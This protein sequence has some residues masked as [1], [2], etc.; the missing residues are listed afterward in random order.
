MISRQTLFAK[1]ELAQRNL[2]LRLN[3]HLVPFNLFGTFFWQARECTTPVWLGPCQ[4][5]PY[6]YCILLCS[7]K[8]FSSQWPQTSHKYC[9]SGKVWLRYHCDNSSK[10][11]LYLIFSYFKICECE[12]GST[13]ESFNLLKIRCLVSLFL[14]NFDLLVCIETEQ[15]IIYFILG[16]QELFRR[17][18]QGACYPIML[19][20]QVP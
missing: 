18:G 4:G 7:E 13:S 14:K 5:W 6:T 2:D 8:H 11:K 10:V 17:E 16:T 1:L 3:H 20:Y 12:L 19:F 15:Y 9:I